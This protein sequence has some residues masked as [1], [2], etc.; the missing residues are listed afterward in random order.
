MQKIQLKLI[1]DEVLEFN[2]QNNDLKTKIQDCYDC[3]R[4]INIKDEYNNI[5]INPNHIIY[6]KFKNI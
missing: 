6:A 1:T 3:N 2:K 4:L 5:F